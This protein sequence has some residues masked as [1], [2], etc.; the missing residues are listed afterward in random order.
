MQYLLSEGNRISQESRHARF[1]SPLATRDNSQVCSLTHQVELPTPVMLSWSDGQAA[2]S[3]QHQPINVLFILAVQSC[4]KSAPRCSSWKLGSAP[5][6]F[7]MNAWG[8][9]LYLHQGL[10]CTA[11]RQGSV[12]KSTPHHFHQ[13]A[14]LLRQVSGTIPAL[15]SGLRGGE[16]P[17]LESQ[18]QRELRLDP[19]AGP[20]S[21]LNSL[22]SASM[23]PEQQMPCLAGLLLTSPASADTAMPGRLQLLL[24]RTSDADMDVVLHIFEE[25]NDDIRVR[26]MGVSGQLQTLSCRESQQSSVQHS[27][28]CHA[29]L[30]L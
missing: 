14:P 1:A 6:G 23:P 4:T 13:A 15:G 30:M 3:K 27:A 5:A 21:L 12:C 26:V 19:P 17:S 11:K 9:R 24:W 28:S 8:F 2:W 22:P 16:G 25:T 20:Q 29:E 18:L 10:A 7:C